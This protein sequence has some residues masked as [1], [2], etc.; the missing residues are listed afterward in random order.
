M[1]NVIGIDL[2]TTNSEVAVFE[3]DKVRLIKNTNDDEITPSAVAKINGEIKVGEIAKD[4]AILFPENTVLEIKRKMGDEEKVTMAEE[5]Y[6]S[7]EISARILKYL[8]D[9]AENDVGAIKEAVITVP[10]KFDDL[11][12]RATKDA[13]YIAGLKVDRIINEPTAAALAYGLDFYNLEENILVYDLGG[14]TFDVSILEFMGDDIFDVLVSEGNNNLGGRDF[15]NKILNYINDQ[16]LDDHGIDLKSNA[17]SR[18][19][20]KSL[21]EKIKIE[22]SSEEYIDIFEQ[23]IASDAE[24]NPL[25]IDLTVSR[26]QF[27]ELIAEYLKETEEVIEKA[28]KAA[29]LEIEEIDTVIPV[30]GSTRIPAVKKLLQDKFAARISYKA[31]PDLIVAKGAAIQAAIKNDS[32]KEMDPIMT[33]VCPGS[34]GVEI[35]TNIN[36][37]W[38]NGV[39]DSLIDVNTTIPVTNEKI[40]YTSVDNQK[41]VDVK[42][43]QGEESIAA[44]NKQIAELNVDGIPEAPAGEEEIKVKFS[45]N[46][47]GMLEIE[48]TI[49][50][51]GKKEIK[52]INYNSMKDDEKVAAKRRLELEW[53][54]SSIYEESEPAID[55]SAAKKDKELAWQDSVMAEEVET[56]IERAEDIKEELDVQSVESLDK[57]LKELKSALVEENEDKVDEYEEKLTDI[58]FDLI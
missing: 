26:T 50:S 6:L 30:G 41:A 51:T 21:S 22:L 46:L 23:G 33:D 19:R 47:N 12:R 35:I 42:V 7:Q 8:K 34:L 18:Q 4:N 5:E 45:Y 11:Q 57:I 44:K 16:F 43:F 49:L 52:K 10:A 40:Y 38:I 2:G 28:L 1:S 48:V 31:N 55:N 27:E 9:C 29:K 32:F 53:N 20:L 17:Q 36:G 3:N 37:N 14:G 15:D 58:L 25:N 13:A 56:L 24:G 39:F 54:D